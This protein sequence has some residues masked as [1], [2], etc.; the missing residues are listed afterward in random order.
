MGVRAPFLRGKGVLS[1]TVDKPPERVYTGW[2]GGKQMRSYRNWLRYLGEDL[3]EVLRVM[4]N[5]E[6]H[7]DA[8]GE[9]MA[10]YRLTAGA[11]NELVERVRFYVN[12]K[13]TPEER[14][15]ATRLRE[16]EDGLDR[17]IAGYNSR[18]EW[19]ERDQLEFDAY[20]RGETSLDSG[21]DVDGA[22]LQEREP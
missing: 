3:L 13:S 9:R 18:S 15:A 10:A 16:A 11:L 17:L 7:H 19:S 20:H 1:G 5:D 21:A 6:W 22:E 14:I 4:E 2:A 8:A 12:A